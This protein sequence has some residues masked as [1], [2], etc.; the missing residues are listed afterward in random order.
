MEWSNFKRVRNKER[1]TEGE[2][3]KEIKERRNKSGVI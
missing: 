3:D 1:E 2:S